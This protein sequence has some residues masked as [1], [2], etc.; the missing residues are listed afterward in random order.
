MASSKFPNKMNI[1]T[2][3]LEEYVNIVDLTK[4]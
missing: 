1:K 2:I 3:L 4:K